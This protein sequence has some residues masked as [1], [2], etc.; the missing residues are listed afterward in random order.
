MQKS[1]KRQKQSKTEKR[2]K[3]L[4]L[5]YF[6]NSNHLQNILSN[7]LSFSS[8]VE[9]FIRKKPITGSIF[10]WYK[11]KNLLP[12]ESKFSVKFLF[13]LSVFLDLIFTCLGIMIICTT[14]IISLYILAK[15]VGFTEYISR[16]YL[17]CNL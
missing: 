11:T 12:S 9:K 6:G 15:G 3:F 14:L 1:N 8:F 10:Y 4:K 16:C 13:L 5:K 17:N 2:N 7:H